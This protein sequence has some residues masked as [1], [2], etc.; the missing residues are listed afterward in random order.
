MEFVLFVFFF[1][2]LFDV[3]HIFRAL[4]VNF[5]LCIDVLGKYNF[6]FYIYLQFL[7]CMTIC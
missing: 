6:S 2:C 4:H 7:I 1:F 3:P 5:D